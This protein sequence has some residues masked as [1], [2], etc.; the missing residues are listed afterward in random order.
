MYRSASLFLLIY[1]PFSVLTSNGMYDY[2]YLIANNVYW[3][4]L[5]FFLSFKCKVKLRK[6]PHFVIGNQK[7][8]ENFINIFGFVKSKG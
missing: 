5:I 7:I 3:F 4:V 6:L 8:G 1:T 2:K